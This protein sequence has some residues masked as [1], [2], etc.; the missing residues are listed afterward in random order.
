M[1]SI[2]GSRD[3]E[4]V[5][6][7][8]ELQKH[9]SPDDQGWVTDGKY[10]IGMGRLAIVDTSKIP[11][12]FVDGNHVLTYNGEI[13]NHAELR[14]E[15]LKKGH[16]FTTHSDTEVVLKAYKEWGV[17]CLDKFNGMYA[18]AIYDGKQLFLARDIAGEKPLYY[19]ENPFEFASEAKAL[20]WDCKEFPPAHYGVYDFRTKKLKLTRY[21]KSTIRSI[22][23]RT[24]QEELEWLLGDSV[25][26]RTQADVPYGLYLSEGVD[27]N[28][29]KTFHN[30]DNTFTYKD[31]NYKRDFLRNVEKIV[32]HLDYP[33][34]HFTPYALWRLA[35]MA[36]EGVK[37]VLSGEGADEL[38][39][40]Y[41]RYVPTA[42]NYYAK[43]KYP[44]YSSMFPYDNY[45][46][47]DPIT[48][49]GITEFSTNLRELLRMG[50]RMASAFGIE[51]RCPFLDKRIIDFA[52]SLPPE[53]KINLLDTK[54][55]LRD[56]LQKRNPEYK[57]VEKHGLAPPINKWI[58]AKGGKYDKTEWLKYQ[59]TILSR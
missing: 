19:K 58:G 48:G 30:F 38:F 37:V 14:I 29:L 15:L 42:L 16:T 31:G 12:P 26:L 52:F 41:V 4:Q 25:R 22:D 45:G 8:L 55:I 43:E 21:W 20:N 57:E 34:K 2:A 54:V 53:L 28:L 59:K 24:A 51:N 46:K 17:R 18:F 23:P 27:S 35:R 1:C 50:D 47:V 33:T 3:F 36:S 7:M 9:R 40:G 39:G 5:E 32:W 13:Y 56:I 11:T 6:R 44:S 49:M 10:T